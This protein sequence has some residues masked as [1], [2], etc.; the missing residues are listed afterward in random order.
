MA[1]VLALSPAPA[2]EP[3]RG[4]A[5]RLDL[6]GLGIRGMTW[7]EPLGMVLLIA[8]PQ[9]ESAG[10][11]RLYEWSGEPGDA[12]ALVQAISNAPSDSAP[13][14]IIPYPG[15]RDVQIL[16]DQGEHLIDGDACKDADTGD[17]VFTDTI[18]H[19]P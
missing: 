16:F 11:F 13:E 18:V 9:D 19:L 12:T 2:R 5:A 8:G 14:A 15:T 3:R 6:G 10:P 17:Q 7:S 1:S 4:Q